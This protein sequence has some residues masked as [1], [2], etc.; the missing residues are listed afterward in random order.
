MAKFSDVPAAC[1]I[2]MINFDLSRHIHASPGVTNL[3]TMLPVM[4]G[5][6]HTHRIYSSLFT[7]PKTIFVVIQ[8]R[9]MIL[10]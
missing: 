7:S 8:S 2:T 6:Y 5:Y 3:Q 9:E 4:G 10:Y 1:R